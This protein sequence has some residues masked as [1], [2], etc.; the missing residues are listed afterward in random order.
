MVNEGAKLLEEGVAPRPHEIDVA[1]VN[2]LGFPSYV[3]GPMFWADQIGLDKVL[4]SI[5][6]F[7]AEHGDDYWTPSALLVR[8]AGEGRGFYG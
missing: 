1:M 2:G 3:G 7:R 5:E 8:L 6:T 4:A